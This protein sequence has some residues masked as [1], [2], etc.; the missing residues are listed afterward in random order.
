MSKTKDL[1]NQRFDRLVALAPNG[2]APN[3]KGSVITWDCLCDCG[4]HITVRGADLTKRNTRSCGCIRKEH[5]NSLKHRFMRR[6]KTTSEAFTYLAA[7]GRC[8]NPNNKDWADYGGRGI[9]FRFHSLEQFLEVL[10]PRPKGLTLDR[11]ENNGH[12]EPG[13]VRWAT[14]EQQQNNRRK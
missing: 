12:Y 11:I 9:E 5:P 13:N 8:T 3:G 1:T 4:E 7:K 2:R 14:W 6:G 10:G